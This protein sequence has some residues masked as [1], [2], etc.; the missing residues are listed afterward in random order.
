MKWF[1]Y[2]TL[3]AIILPASYK[4][5][6][7]LDYTIRYQK[8]VK[9]LCIN[10]DVPEKKC[11]G[12]CQLAITIDSS[13]SPNEPNAPNWSQVEIGPLFYPVEKIDNSVTLSELQEVPNWQ[14]SNQYAFQIIDKIYHPPKAS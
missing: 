9:E 2:I 3:F 12:K 11:N 7:L 5:G 13:E 14:Y 8:Y 4:F 10:K 1:V 6:V